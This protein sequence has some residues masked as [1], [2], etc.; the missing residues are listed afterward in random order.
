M[1]RSANEIHSTNKALLERLKKLR[2]ELI[3]DACSKLKINCRNVIDISPLDKSMKICGTAYTIEYADKDDP[4]HAQ[5]EFNRFI[6]DNIPSDSVIVI[7]NFGNIDAATVWGELVSLAAKTKGILGTITNGRIRDADKIESLHYPV[8][9]S[10]KHLLGSNEAYKIVA[11]KTT[12]KLNGV[13]INHGDIILADNSG[14]VVIDLNDLNKIIECAETKDRDE[15]KISNLIKQK[16]S[17]AEIH[18]IMI[19]NNDKSANASFLPKYKISVTKFSLFAAL[20]TSVVLGA[21]YL[22]VNRKH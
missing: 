17:L 14:I 6:I 19:S 11:H 10:G 2:T 20:T 1:Q 15:A 3:A 12:V 9:S 8:F 4:R 22:C 13:T 21:T 18:K 16:I 5:Y 7:E